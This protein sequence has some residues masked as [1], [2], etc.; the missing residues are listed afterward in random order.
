MTVH[1]LPTFHDLPPQV[2]ALGD[3]AL[4]AGSQ[5]DGDRNSQPRTHPQF[6]SLTLLGA[7]T[8]DGASG[9]SV[10]AISLTR[11]T[12]GKLGNVV[13]DFVDGEAVSGL[14]LSEC[15]SETHTQ[16]PAPV[17]SHEPR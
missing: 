1:G 13:V 9:R 15:G 16:V 11:G 2:G 10:A 17:I 5:T 4:E 6:Y 12:G 7:S 3:A 8:D 14:H